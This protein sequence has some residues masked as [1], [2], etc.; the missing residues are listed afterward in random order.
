MIKFEDERLACRN[1]IIEQPL[2][3]NP[4]LPERFQIKIYDLG[5]YPCSLHIKAP[6]VLVNATTFEQRKQSRWRA[7][8][9]QFLIKIEGFLAKYQSD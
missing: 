5:A 9:K 6:I 1:Y 3:I 8:R 4:W 7:K 2:N